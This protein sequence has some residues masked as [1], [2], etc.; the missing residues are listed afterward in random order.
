MSNT[1]AFTAVAPLAGSLSDL[2]G[3]RSLALAAPLIMILGISL[4]G[5]AKGMPVAIAGSAISGVGQGIAQVIG[6]AGVAEL[7]PVRARG[8]FIGTIY[9]CFFPGA[10]AASYGKSL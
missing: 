5:T 9:L 1:I 8:K 7:V 3:R 2:T 6:L 10:G 4:Y